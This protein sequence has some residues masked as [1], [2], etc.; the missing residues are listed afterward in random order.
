MIDQI[1]PSLVGNHKK[2][3]SQFLR[4]LLR[5]SLHSFKSTD[6]L[7]HILWNMDLVCSE[8]RSCQLRYSPHKSN[9][10]QPMDLFIFK[11]LKQ[12]KYIYEYFK[13][14][15]NRIQWIKLISIQ[16]WTFCSPNKFLSS[17]KWVIIFNGYQIT[18]YLVRINHD[19]WTK[20]YQ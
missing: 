1:C 19:V 12:T 13:S 17:F 11:I 6:H 4:A 5:K 7:S 2:F 8:E 14:F 3:Y 16:I 10:F 15:N 20:K 18:P 9:I